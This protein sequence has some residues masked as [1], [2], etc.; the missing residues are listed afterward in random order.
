MAELRT[1]ITENREKMKSII[2]QTKSTPIELIA[3][4]GFSITSPAEIAV[5]SAL[6]DLYSNNTFTLNEAVKQQLMT[7]IGGTE[8]KL[9]VSISRLMKS[10]ALVR[11]GKLIGLNVA[12]KDCDQIEQLV[13]RTI[14]ADFEKEKA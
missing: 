5:L 9:K 14:P 8:G 4:Y 3:Q 1:K 12:F 7:K 11:S 10:G 2:I 13:L 6:Y